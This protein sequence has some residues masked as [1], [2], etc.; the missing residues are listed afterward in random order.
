MM[1]LKQ[2]T[3]ITVKIGPFLD[4]TDGKTAETAL[5][6]SQADV[7]LSKNGGNYAQKNEAT[8]CTHDELGEYDCSLDTTDTN[9]LGRLRLMVQES[10]AL[11]VWHDYMVVPANV[12]DS[13]FGADKL[14]VHADEITA[15]LITAAAVATGAIDADAI[16]ANAIT[17]SEIADG[18][19]TAAKIAANAIT[20]TELADGAI[21][22][23]KIATDAIGSD[24]LAATAA[25]E[26][27]DQVWDEAKSGHVAGGSFGEEIQ[28]HSLSSEIAALNDLSA[29]EV[30]T[31]VDTA[32]SDIDL[33]HLIQVTAGAEEPTDGSY[34]D[35]I[36]HKDVSQTFDPTTDSLEALRDTDPLGT[37]MR[38]T[39]NAALASVCTEGRLSELDAANIPSDV[40][41]ILADTG[42]DGV[43]LANDAI[44][45]AKIAADA[46]TSSELAAS[47][48]QEIAD[49]VW[50]EAKSGHVAAGS[51]GEEVQAHAL[52]SE[53]AALNDVSTAEV[54]AEVDTA[55]A[56]IDLDHL[57]Q[58]TAGV[59]EPTDGS[60]LDQIMHKDGSQTFDATTDSLEAL[61]DTAPMGTA[62]RGTDS[63]AL[64]SVC[65][66]GRLSELDA[67]N[68]PADVDAILADTG[69][70]GVLLAS[71]SV[72]A[73]V[74]A[75]GAIDADAIAANAITSSEIAD[76]AIT[77]AKIATDAIGASELAAG[78]VAEIAD[79]VWDE[80]ASGHLTSGTFGQRLNLIRAGTA[81]AGA[82]GSI[83]LDAGASAVDNFYDGQVIY[84]TG[85]TGAGQSRRIDTYTGST[86]VATI[87][88]NWGTNPDNTSIFVLIPEGDV[89]GA[90][91]PTAAQVADAVWDE[92]AADHLTSGSFGQRLNVVRAGTAQ[93]GAAG[94]ITLDAG[95]SATDN[96]YDGQVVY[97]TG[98]TGA[99]QSRRIDTYTGSTKVATVI[100]NWATTPD[101]TTVFALIPEGDVPGA[102][103][104]TAAQ[105]ADAVWDE[106]STGHVDAGKAGA[107][108]WTDIDAILADTGADG[109]VLADGAITAAKIATDA[110]GSDGLAASGVQE[111]ADQ[112]WDETKSG[113]VAAGSFGEEVQAHS[114]SSEIAALNDPTAAAIADA[115]W[116]EASSGHVDAGKAG[117]QLWTDVDAIL[118]D[119]GTDGVI[120]ANNAITAAKIAAD[121]ITSSE[122]AASAVQEIA[123]QIWDEAKSGHVGV[124]SFG[125]EVQAHSLSTEIAALNDP[126]AAAIADAIWDELQSG[127]ISAGSFGEIATEIASI[128]A[129]TSTDGVAISTAI[130]QAIADEILK[131]GIS[132]VED[133]ADTT[134][135]TA[136]VLA[137]FES[138]ISGTA[139]TIR[140]TDGT[141]FNTKTV[142]PDATADPITGVT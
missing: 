4:D 82:A 126:T 91:A 90:S 26:I 71:G 42:T 84:I 92:A 3:A 8:S 38:G 32:L 69:T 46:I 41:D 99:G 28:A 76:G 65:T 102:S 110:I 125:E 139:W 137:A 123:D 6:I 95:A 2:S 134:S 16:A 36:M 18:A 73:A 5:T 7:R 83:T 40:D 64:A 114:L 58:V 122:L 86:K 1:W 104:P 25:Q 35:Q 105:V 70:D 78:A 30:N 44:T 124:G 119:T 49:Q 87:S 130:A 52:S 118:A 31:E 61:R 63:A 89:P 116:D 62:M 19:I 53:I 81:Q 103:A 112:V 68:I 101:N 39:D 21:T 88:P 9:T 47:A 57:I 24:E 109:V 94:S 98:G 127:H 121:A 72:T 10:G 115:V 96:F 54:N 85:G 67:A 17:S 37:A 135:L 74:V 55:L 48:V 129:D 140:K 12:W 133:A 75:T 131:R 13:L 27:A 29:A 56:D 23:A 51:F 117:A 33:D 100:P 77:A 66:E 60:Y 22:A 142:T 20:S 128:L 141:T 111:I 43:V 138:S 97:L 113:H 93:A 136:L 120:L 79:G 108:L 80:V 132:N 50:D 15:G 34:L 59:E 106:A 107:Q 45:A 14:Q 11:P